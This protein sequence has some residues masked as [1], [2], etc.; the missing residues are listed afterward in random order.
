MCRILDRSPHF[1]LCEGIRLLIEL[2]FAWER[3]QRTRRRENSESASAL[4]SSSQSSE[5]ALDNFIY[6]CFKPGFNP[7]SS[8]PT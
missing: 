7:S 1:E 8:S 5:S 2:S 3:F 6:A 4:D